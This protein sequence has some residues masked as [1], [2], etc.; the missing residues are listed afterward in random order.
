[1][2]KIKT[3]W[4]CLI[5]SIAFLLC[6][7]NVYA[8]TTVQGTCGDNL[9]WTF[10]SNGTLTISG[11]GSMKD[12]EIVGMNN[13]PNTPWL[14]CDIKNIVIDNGV[15]YIGNYAFSQLTSLEKL[16][17]AD[18]VLSMG[19]GIFNGDS[20]LKDVYF[21][22]NL[23]LETFPSFR[24]CTSLESISMPDSVKI[25]PDEC[26]YNCTSLKK[27]VLSQSLQSIGASSFEN[28]TKLETIDFPDNL[29]NIYSWAF[30]NCDSLVSINI[31]DSVTLVG[32][33]A[34]NSCDNLTKVTWSQNATTIY[35]STFSGCKSLIDFDFPDTLKEI[36]ESAFRGTAFT[37]LNLPEGLE[38]IRSGAFYGCQDLT[39]VEI[40]DSVTAINISIQDTYHRDG[41]GAF[42]EC[43][44]LEYLK[45]GK[46]FSAIGQILGVKHPNLKMVVFPSTAPASSADYLSIGVYGDL[47]L[48]Y[49]GTE[50]G[51]GNSISAYTP[52]YIYE[53][54]FDANGGINAPSYQ[55]KIPGTSLKLTT[56]TPQKAGYTFKSW[57]TNSTGS[58]KSYS[59]GGNFSLDASTTLY[60]QWSANSYYVMFN[61]NGGTTS[62]SLKTVKYNSV[63]GTLPT[64]NRDGY[65]FKGWYTSAIGG[66]KVTSSTVFN[67]TESIILYAQWEKSSYKITYNTNGGVGNVPSA[68]AYSYGT[69]A[70]ITDI[71]PSRDGYEFLGWATRA[72]ASEAEHKAN[73][74]YV[75]CNDITF[76]AVWKAIPSISAELTAYS[77]YSLCNVVLNNIDSDCIIIFVKYKNGGLVS[78]EIRDY[79]GNE[80]MYPI[81]EDVDTVK[82]FVVDNKSHMMPLCKN[83]ILEMD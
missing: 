59:S 62:T 14:S 66:T 34:F 73:D 72:D 1:M 4:L 69:K 75:V 27:V 76:Y 41:D 40:P 77:S 26:F 8:S 32:G 60:A 30:K 39:N 24:Y 79:A 31:P 52:N 50:E 9:T 54:V 21:S 82:V 53:V 49:C 63:Y 44:A 83:K 43:S 35:G 58:G 29:N 56:R 6:A 48:Y 47:T 55:P 10:D 5:F 20:L 18:S 25:I 65:I 36:G 42:R 57:N 37:S 15:T 7:I 46:G 12:F 68:T 45:I 33:E 19:S 51:W 22:K 3:I 23:E 71:V 81:F 61:A 80:E 70:I 38:T 74:E 2:K 78:A 17:M 13:V 11:T 28:C 67:V 16:T 64:A